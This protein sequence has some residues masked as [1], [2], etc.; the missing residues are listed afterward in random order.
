LISST[1]LSGSVAGGTVVSITGSRLPNEAL[2]CRFNNVASTNNT[3]L[4]PSSF[5]C[6][7]PPG[8]VGTGPLALYLNG[9]P[10]ADS[11]L[12]FEYYSLFPFFLFSFFSFFLSFC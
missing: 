11:S 3:Y 12:T 5:R 7:S 8:T 6:V 9:A 1:P 2:Q 10:I 4:N